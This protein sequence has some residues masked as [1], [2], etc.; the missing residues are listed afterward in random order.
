MPAVRTFFLISET[1]PR[2]RKEKGFVRDETRYTESESPNAALQLLSEAQHN[3]QTYYSHTV[4][5]SYSHTV[6][7][8]E[9]RLFGELVMGPGLAFR[10]FKVFLFRCRVPQ[11]LSVR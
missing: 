8:S 7:L 2:L 1:N 9:V 4:V 5:Q 6:V 11:E 3:K 10:S